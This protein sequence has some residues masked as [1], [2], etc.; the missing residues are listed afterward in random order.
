MATTDDHEEYVI[1]LYKGRNEREAEARTLSRSNR[2]YKKWVGDSW[3]SFVLY[4]MKLSEKN[5]VNFR[6]LTERDEVWVT[7]NVAKMTGLFEREENYDNE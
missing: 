6:G 1:L 5:F 3:D 7:E 2:V 4:F